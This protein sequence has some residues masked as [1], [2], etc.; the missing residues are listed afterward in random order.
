LVS[1]ALQLRQRHLQGGL[2][3]SMRYRA[4]QKE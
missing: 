2:K 1:A 4:K 3:A